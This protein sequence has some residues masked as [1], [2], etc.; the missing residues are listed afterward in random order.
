MA[1][2]VVPGCVYKIDI[3]PAL[4]DRDSYCK[5]AMSRRENVLGSID[6]AV[7]F[8]ATIAA[9]PLSYSQTC[10]TFRTAGGDAPQHEQV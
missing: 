1:A 4:K 3:L 10:S 9:S 8:R 6:V 5:T 2:A 7:V